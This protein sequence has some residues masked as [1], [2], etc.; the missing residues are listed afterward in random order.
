MTRVILFLNTQVGLEVAKFLIL[1]K[2]THIDSVFL[3]NQYPEID[4]KIRDFFLDTNTEVYDIN[5][6][7]KIIY[8]KKNIDYLICVYWPYL[9]KKEVI[10]QSSNTI[11]FHPAYLPINRGW[12]PHVHS[13]IDGSPAGVTLHEINENADEGDIIVQKKIKIPQNF[14]AGEAYKLLQNKILTLFKE[15]WELIK[16]EKIVKT[17]QKHSFSNYHKKNEIKKLDFIDIKLKENRDLINQLRARSFGEKGF[18]YFIDDDGDK[19]FMNLKLS[20]KKYP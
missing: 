14:C 16:S 17:K 4:D 2:K 10:N 20:K 15:N 1:D 9:L 13:I 8:S 5:N 3:S 7:E 18:A 12:Y 19:V 11:N 6:L